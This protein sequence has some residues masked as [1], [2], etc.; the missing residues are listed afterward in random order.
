MEKQFII[1][2]EFNMRKKHFSIALTM[3]VFTGTS[4]SAHANFP[5]LPLDTAQPSLDIF[6]SSNPLHEKQYLKQRVDHLDFRINTND[7]DI[8]R[9]QKDVSDIRQSTDNLADIQQQSQ[10]YIE[11]QLESSQKLNDIKMESTYNR[12][13]EYTN[14]NFKTLQDQN[15]EELAK[16]NSQLSGEIEDVSNHLEGRISHLDSHYNQ[17]VNDLGTKFTKLETG[18]SQKI[19]Q[20]EEKINKTGRHANSGIASVAAMSNIPYALHTRFSAGVGMGHYKNGKAI[21]AGAQYQVRKNV[22][23]RSSIAWNNSNSPVIG[24]GVA[25]GW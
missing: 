9:L 22:N 5:L 13:K 3:F 23:L 7:A 10:K 19:N 6:S 15:T 14:F 8:F 4:F 21:A 24:A 1:D 18:Y 2:K 11:T 16:L 17:A 20:L 25:V 12:S